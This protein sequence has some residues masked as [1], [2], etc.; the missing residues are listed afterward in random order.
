LVL[1]QEN[2]KGVFFLNKRDN[3]LILILGIGVFSIMNT[4]FA[5]IGILPHM[6]DR[7]DVS[8]SQAGL[9][10]SAF[11]LTI[12]ICGIIMPPLFSGVNR[13]TIM[14]LVLGLFLVSNVVT[15]FTTNY[16]VAMMARIIPAIFHPVYF[17]VAFSTAA[18]LVDRKD[19][20]KAVSKVFMGVSAGMVVGVPIASFFASTISIQASLLYFLIVGTVVFLLTLIFFPSMPVTEKLSYGQQVSVL[21]KGAVWMSIASALLV[22]SAI[23]GVYGYFTEYLQTVTNLSGPS[24]TLMLFLF[25]GANIVGTYLAG[26]LFTSHAAK[27]VIF[28]PFILGV[29]YIILFLTGHLF[30]AMTVLTLAFGLLAGLGNNM[31]QYMI[32]SSAP[33]APDFTNGLFVTFA[34]LGTTIGTAIGGL[35]I[36][37]LGTQYLLLV[38]I[39]SL[40]LAIPFL[41]LRNYYLKRPSHTSVAHKEANNTQTENSM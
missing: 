31:N 29:V 12:A 6:A 3:L 34:N 17:A 40:V 15:L 37:G 25:G 2:K 39:I 24:I 33:E 1:P 13:R 4:E 26:R 14:L 21:K 5:I 30:Y 36:A 10:V 9:L 27:T 35:F 38:G 22:S 11:A 41:L 23:F 8:I 7:L 28:F 32:T 18:S 19:A 20:P 16:T